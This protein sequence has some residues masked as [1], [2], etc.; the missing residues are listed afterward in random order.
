MRESI[1]SVLETVEADGDNVAGSSVR[2]SAAWQWTCNSSCD[3]SRELRAPENMAM[4]ACEDAS[5]EG[6]QKGAES[7][8]KVRTIV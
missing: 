4:L 2:T 3:C 1:V 6:D 7:G 5:V 8:F